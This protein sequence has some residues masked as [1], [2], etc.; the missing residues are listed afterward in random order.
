MAAE[1]IRMEPK[2]SVNERLREQNDALREIVKTMDANLTD[3]AKAAGAALS[4]ELATRGR[5]ERLEAVLGR[6]FVGRLT[7][8]FLGR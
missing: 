4:N 7:W 8:V 1:V 5:V 2:K 6:G 3:L